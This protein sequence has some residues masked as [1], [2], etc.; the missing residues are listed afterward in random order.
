MASALNL[1][2]YVSPVGCLTIELKR[3]LVVK[4]SKNGAGVKRKFTA[5][6]KFEG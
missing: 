5:G 3:L 6:E 4:S 2:K 1:S